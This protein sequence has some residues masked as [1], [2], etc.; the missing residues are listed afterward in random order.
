MPYNISKTKLE[1]F[2]FFSICS[3]K[4]GYGH[5]KRIQNLISILKD[6][7]SKMYHYSYGEKIK[8]IDLFLNKLDSEISVKNK[9][10]LDF[11]NKLFL[12]NKTILKI[13]KILGKKK[14]QNIYII[15]EPTIKNLSNILNLDN[16]KTLIP[17]EVEGK[18]RKKLTKFK[19]NRIGFE[20][21]IYPT[22]KI[23]KINR[24]NDMVLSFGGSDNYE[25]A[26]YVLKL[27][28]KIKIKK[29]VAVVIG[30][31]NKA[32]YKK[33]I[34]SICKKNNFKI[35]KFTKNFNNILNKSKLLITNSGMTK[36]E[37]V[38]HG[39]PVIVFSDSKESQKIDKVFINKT[40]QFHFSYLRREQSDFLKLKNILIKQ[41]KFKLFDKNLNK[42]YT[43][44]IKFFFKK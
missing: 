30:K 37:G 32:S 23:K 8:D 12:N 7:K 3:K 27:L 31:Y 18:I 44:K 25:G 16:I 1:K 11:T 38:V 41:E 39:I 4:F 42:S 9:V 28:E 15:D 20:Y 21:F 36:Y 33:K 17:F 29:N 22:N 35:V 26:F 2:S 13:K 10:I 43:S 40:K 24:V 14:N 6:H 5:Y 19:R 34:F